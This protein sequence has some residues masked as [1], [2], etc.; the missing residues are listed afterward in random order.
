VRLEKFK[1]TLPFRNKAVGDVTTRDVDL[2][3][4]A[5]HTEVS[6]YTHRVLTPWSILRDFGL[7][8][9]V[10]ARAVRWRWIATSPFA[11]AECPPKG[12]ER[13]RKWSDMD[14]RKVCLALGYNF[15]STP[16][17]RQ[18]HIAWAILFALETAARRG[19]ILQSTHEMIDYKKRT[20]AMPAKI[21]KGRR[22]RDIPLSKEALALLK[23]AP[24]KSG[25]LLPGLTE[26]VC[27]QLVRRAVKRAG[28]GDLHFHDTRRTATTRLAD[29]YDVLQL[30]A[31]TGHAD[32]QLLKDTY[33]APDITSLAE[34]MDRAPKRKGYAS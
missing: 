28:C 7:L 8:R 19:E 22:A 4:D 13:K 16:E 27:D 5:L 23:V 3:R 2:W 34:K 11:G 6:E 31:I 12:D 29:I 30:A 20:Y 33:Y 1:R 15:G 14:V 17:T 21:T 10:F 9:S 25:P 26:K 32:L 18:Q 24:T